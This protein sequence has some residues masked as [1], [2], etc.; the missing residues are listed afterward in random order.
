MASPTMTSTQRRVLAVA[1]LASF[2][3]FL[4]GTI[5]N[6]A[7]PAIQRDLGGGLITQQWTV[8]A[9]LI[10]LG[11][12][13]LVAGS[14]SD[15]F[16]RVLVLRIG[17]IGFGIA[18]IAVG[19]AP[20]PI[21]LI[22]ARAVQGA[23]GAFL[24]PSSLALITSTFEGHARGRAIGIW[25]G[26]TTIAMIAGPLLGGLLVD[27]ASW[28]YAF[29]INVVPIAITLWLVHPLRKTDRRMPDAS[30]DWLGAILC[31]VGLGA[32]VFALIEQPNLGW[33]SPI[34]WLSLGGGILLFGL[35]LLRQRTARSPILPLGLFRARNFWAGN[36]A[37]TFVYA[38]LSLNGFVV[39]VYLQQGAGLPATLAGLASL[40]A[41]AMM[42]LLSSRA[43]A[44]SD[45]FGPRFFMTVGP[46][47]MAIGS[48]LLLTVSPDFNYWLQVL[49]G[50]VLFGLGLAT[51]VSPLT[52][53]VLGAVDTARS[54]IASAVNNAV[55][56]VAGLLAV[57]M[58]AAITGGSLDL[59]GF[60]RSAIVT[61][62]LLTAGGI[63]S[64]LGI[65]NPPHED[66]RLSP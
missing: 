23:A 50:I 18:S 32:A 31:T 46:L 24:V 58:L 57:A 64:F 4:D 12:L 2:V 35:F 17:L 54:G 43:G 52:S 5:V 15:A 16:G 41:T 22:V 33:D 49:P 63:A 27:L 56:R 34:I 39:A 25:T 60:H 29:L 36:V 1:I 13:I 65:R 20:D 14:V 59:T 37:T 51:T 3:A 62:V 30:I 6:V 21:F 61:A 19:L 11:S 44:L 7:L 28:R 9:Y 48:L 26:L 40:P 10:T 47:V 55:A 66:A 53:A 8:D 38:A 45:T 42:I